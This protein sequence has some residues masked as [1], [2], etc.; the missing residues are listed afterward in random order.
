MLCFRK[1]PVAKKIAD[2][3]G[4]Q[5]FP[6]N[7]FFCLRMPKNLVGEP[8]S[9]SLISGIGK[10]HPSEGCHNFLSNFFV[11]QYRKTP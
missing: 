3:G 7:V 8:F 6:L 11:S 2:K 9:V 1:I 10:F 5:V 4:H